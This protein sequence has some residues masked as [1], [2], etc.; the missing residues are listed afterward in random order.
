MAKE[1]KLL[2]A[3]Y[4]AGDAPD[5]Q[6]ALDEAFAAGDPNAMGAD[7]RPLRAETPSSSPVPALGTALGARLYGI[8]GAVF[9]G[10]L[11]SI[12]NDLLNV[13]SPSVGAATVTGAL[14][15]AGAGVGRAAATGTRLTRAMSGASGRAVSAASK[16]GETVALPQLAAMVEDFSQVPIASGGITRMVKSLRQN[17]PIDI[18]LVNDLRQEF[19]QL[20]RHPK[21][22]ALYGAL[23]SDLR[24]AAA[25][26]SKPATELLHGLQDLYVSHAFK[27][28]SKGLG[29]YLESAVTGGGLTG[30]MLGRPEAMIPAGLMWGFRGAKAL[31][32]TPRVPN[33]ESLLAGGTVAISPHLNP[34]TE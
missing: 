20:L 1:R 4:T 28:A 3:D 17:M 33:L 26:G 21:G 7:M 13:Q 11:G 19:G 15:G 2:P 5:P 16:S 23:M 32:R 27:P 34:Y 8:P 22:P 25:G 10:A 12:I 29:G 9:G 14:G 31:R 30:A 18:G 24:A 6:H